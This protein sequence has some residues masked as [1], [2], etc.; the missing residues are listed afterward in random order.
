MGRSLVGMPDR[1][2][3]E[4]VTCSLGGGPRNNAVPFDYTWGEWV[5]I[6][7]AGEP[8]VMDN[9]WGAEDALRLVEGTGNNPHGIFLPPTSNRLM[10][11]GNQWYCFQVWARIQERDKVSVVPALRFDVDASGAWFDLTY[12]VV[13]GVQSP[14]L[15][16]ILEGPNGWYLCQVTAKAIST[17]LAGL[18]LSIGLTG[19]YNEAY[20]GDGSSGVSLY[21]PMV[22]VVNPTYPFAI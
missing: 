16:Q 13:G 3:R 4:T 8:T 19:G 6:D 15:A 2:Y 18:S 22:C 12:G 11:V 21:Y 14:A 17:G 5:D 10:V 20:P 1:F 7:V 9:P